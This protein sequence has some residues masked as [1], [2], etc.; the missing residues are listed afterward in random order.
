MPSPMII[1]IKSPAW[2]IQFLQ[3]YFN[4][5]S[6]ILFPTRHDFNSQLDFL[7][8]KQPI[9][10]VYEDFGDQTLNVQLP[11]FENKDIRQNW[12][13][14]EKSQALFICRASSFFRVIFN[15]EMNQS[16][17]LGFNRKESMQIFQ[18]K[19]N[20]GPGT[21]DMLEKSFSRYINIRRLKK[22]RKKKNSV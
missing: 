5:D 11:Y 8:T 20:L 12:Y 21:N 18:E 17:N 15:S 22:S 13:L 3:S 19:Y 6:T 10:W 14:S 4:C 16:L 2:L 7:L 9:E 1:Q